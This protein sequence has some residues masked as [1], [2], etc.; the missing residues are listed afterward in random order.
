M[1]GDK[2]Q[3]C[4]LIPPAAEPVVDEAGFMAETEETETGKTVWCKVSSVTAY[5]IA[6][7]G[8]NT[9]KPSLKVTLWADEYNGEEEVEIDGLMYGVYRTYQTGQDEIE[10]YLE[11][12][13]GVN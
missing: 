5:E 4:T 7:M 2:N 6:T 9:I 3:K 12:K 11:R 13:G 8:Q 1:N 10:L